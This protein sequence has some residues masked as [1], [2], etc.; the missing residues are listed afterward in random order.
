M[1]RTWMK[2]IASAMLFIFGSHYGMADSVILQIDSTGSIQ[3]RPAWVNTSDQSISIVNFDFGQ[4]I[5][6]ATAGVNVDSASTQFKLINA[7][8]YPASVL[9]DTPANC[10]IGASGV[11]NAHVKLV[12]DGAEQVDGASFNIGDATA[13]TY[14]LRFDDAGNYGTM[15]GAV[16]CDAGS[17]TYSF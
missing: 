10:F 1:K 6:G 2:R 5:A 13:H 12:Y 4:R 16:A 14:V 15:S 3:N 8:A 11:T 17:L 7:T 9:L